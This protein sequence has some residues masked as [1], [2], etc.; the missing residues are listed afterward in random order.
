MVTDTHFETKPIANGCDGLKKI[1]YHQNSFGIQKIENAITCDH[2]YIFLNN[3]L[4]KIYQS[5]GI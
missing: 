4:K 3:S 2:I 1:R 5:C